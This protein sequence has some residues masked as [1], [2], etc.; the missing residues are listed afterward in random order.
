MQRKRTEAV[1][2]AEAKYKD[3]VYD[4][5]AVNIPKGERDKWKY[6]A[7]KRNLSLKRLIV[8]GVEEYIENHP[9]GE[10]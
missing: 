1:R 4:R 5:I 10:D 8:C 9:I 2:R 7:E 6:E 3:K